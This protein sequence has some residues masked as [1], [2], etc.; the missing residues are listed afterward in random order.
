MSLWSISFLNLKSFISQN[1][2]SVVSLQTE[3]Q[4]KWQRGGWRYKTGAAPVMGLL[5]QDKIRRGNSTATE[6]GRKSRPDAF[7]LS[8]SFPSCLLCLSAAPQL[9]VMPRDVV[10][11]ASGSLWTSQR[12]KDTGREG[13]KRRRD[14]GSAVFIGRSADSLQGPQ[15]WY[16]FLSL[17]FSIIWWRKADGLLS[18]KQ[19]S[20]NK[21][22]CITDYG[23]ISNLESCLP[24][25]HF[26]TSIPIKISFSKKELAGLYWFLWFCFCSENPQKQSWCK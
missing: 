20:Q 6:K 23:C 9:E 3:W 25:P 1:V 14:D 19:I 21:Y 11:S 15:S 16:H 7:R 22:H 13:K 2:L 26:W 5:S 12:E 17:H 18:M 24:R 10:L 8:R 4:W